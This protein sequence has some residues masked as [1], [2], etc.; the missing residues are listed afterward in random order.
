[1]EAEGYKVRLAQNGRDALQYI[2][3][4]RPDIVIADIEM[5]VL[6]GPEM[7]K[8]LI[9]EDC[10]KELIP[11]IVFSAFPDIRKVPARIGTPYYISKPFSVDAFL[12]LIKRVLNEKKP[13]FPGCALV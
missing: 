10:G 4:K 9:I 7:A 2:K 6:S 3:S 8:M 13:P 5:P 1:M 11:I 12:L